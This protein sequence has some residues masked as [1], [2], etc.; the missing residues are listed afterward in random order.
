MSALPGKKTS[1]QPRHFTYRVNG[2]SDLKVFY[3][4]SVFKTAFQVAP[5][6][7]NPPVMPVQSLGGEAPLGGGHG[8]PLLCSCLENS[9]DRGTW[10]ATD[11][12]VSKSPTQPQQLSTI[13]KRAREYLAS[14]AWHHR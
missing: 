12:R 7:R 4:I 3:V 14:M 5:Q 8:N 9:M 11:H 13:F 10:W 2:T 1:Q 6:V